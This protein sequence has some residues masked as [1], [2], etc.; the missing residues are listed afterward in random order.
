MGI[1]Y[2]GRDPVIGRQVALK[3]IRIAVEDDSEQKEFGERFMRE[4][5]A[6]GILSHP[7]I[8]TVHDVGEDPTTGTSFIAMEYVEGRNL[9][10]LL[11]DKVAYSHTRVAEIIGQVAEALDYAHR[12]GIVHRDVKPANIII[13]PEGRVKITD[14]GIAKIEKSNL[15]ST[16]Q[17]LGTPNYMSPEQVTGEPVDGR[18]D[19]FSLGVVLYELL[20]RKKPFVG[21]N[22]TS[23]SYKIVHDT[24]TPPE[25]YDSSLPAEFGPILSK[26]LAKD[27]DL[28][29]QTGA[30]FA[31]ALY[32]FKAREEERDMLRDLGQMVAEAEKLGPVTVEPG[33]GL[34]EHQRTPSGVFRL[35]PDLSG[36]PLRTSPGLVSTPAATPN[37]PAGV[38]AQPIAA[39]PP[40]PFPP[41]VERTDALRGDDILDVDVSSPG[42][43]IPM[44]PFEAGQAVAPLPA[45][46]LFADVVSQ[47]TEPGFVPPA[48]A[49]PQHSGPTDEDFAAFDVPRD[50]LTE[51][52]SV[53]TTPPASPP[54]ADSGGRVRPV[55]PAARTESVGIAQQPTTAIPV[56]D[57]LPEP[58]EAAPAATA[59]PIESTVRHDRS[60]VPAATAVTKITLPPLPPT[61]EPA[62][63]APPRP[64]P[65]AA[66]A[67]GGKKG[68]RGLIGAVI[69][70]IVIGGAAALLLSRREKPEP[71]PPPPTP[72]PVEDTQ[73]RETTERQR[74]LDEGN[75]LLGEGKADEALVSLREL[76][77][78]DAGYAGV[79]ES[80][81]KAEALVAARTAKEKTSADVE[82]H[83]AAARQAQQAGDDKKVQLEADAVLQLDPENVSAA[84]LKDGAVERLARASDAKKADAAKKKAKAT[85][86]PKVV[87]AV[88]PTAVAV[89][90]PSGPPPPTPATATLRIAF[91]SPFPSGHVM[92]RL[93]DK[94][95]FR[96][97]FEFPK[98]QGGGPVEG[99][100]VVPSGPGELKVWV[101]AADRSVNEYKVIPAVIPGGAG[102]TLMLQVDASRNLTVNIR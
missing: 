24:F 22:L 49:A 59:S 10:E 76:A 38:R 97:S 71:S 60:A 102:K 56:G 30:D 94:E 41:A 72:R 74:L 3:T 57:L 61:P 87:A 25:T 63:P 70:L 68:S 82:Q 69:A 26:A 47:A 43:E 1:V 53:F 32:E 101:I 81:Q 93:N 66:T 54:P 91:E 33:P 6:A 75:R 8:V 88:A 65:V 89:A 62:A 48:S 99:S 90:A 55:T 95:V 86:T 58:G 79:A 73:A 37:G 20:T 52:F 2:L 4:A 100:A 5:Q 9:K 84:A 50:Q 31:L 27:P 96:K 39:P 46:D 29:F 11:K 35:T 51:R 14:F 78:R 64:A 16:G 23:I 44:E 18:S 80:I 13:T 7:H 85:P 17:F 36:D 77:R 92:V 21:E 19:L 42:A 40:D 45:E 15:T 67:S 34:G 28:R 98:K 12:R 83:L